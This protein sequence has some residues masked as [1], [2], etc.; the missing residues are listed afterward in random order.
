MVLVMLND[1]VAL[2]HGEVVHAV[3]KP[4]LCE[5]PPIVGMTERS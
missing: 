4:F 5:M 1:S 2:S 3:S